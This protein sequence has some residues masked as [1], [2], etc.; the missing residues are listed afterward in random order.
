MTS[1]TPPY[2][3]VASR[4]SVCHTYIATSYPI[5]S[6]T[7]IALA[8]YIGNA[9]Y[10]GLKSYVAQPFVTAIRNEAPALNG[11]SGPMDPWNSVNDFPDLSEHPG[12]AIVGD[13]YQ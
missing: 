3:A 11:R 13:T 10:V 6:N 8:P 9:P 5:A 7:S 12:S 4:P 2:V 1:C